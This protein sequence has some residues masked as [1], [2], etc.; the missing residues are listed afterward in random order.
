MMANIIWKIMYTLCGMVGALANGSAPTPFKKAKSKPP[1]I[2]PTSVP[3][4]SV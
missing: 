4:A 2:E 3:K 1:M